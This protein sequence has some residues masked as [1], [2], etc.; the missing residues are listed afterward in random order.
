MS[1]KQIAE[2]LGKHP[3]TIR[4]ILPK[5]VQEGEVKTIEY[6]KYIPLEGVDSVDS[7]DTSRIKKDETRNTS[8]LFEKK[9]CTSE[10]GKSTES[11]EST[12]AGKP[13]AEPA[14][15]A[16][17][18]NPLVPPPSPAASDGAEPDAERRRLEE[19]IAFA[20][21]DALQP[22]TLMPSGLTPGWRIERVPKEER[23]WPLAGDCTGVFC[24]GECVCG[25]HLCDACACEAGALIDNHPWYYERHQPR[26]GARCE[27]C[28]APA[29]VASRW[30]T[31]MCERC[32]QIAS[33]G[34]GINPRAYQP[35]PFGPIEGDEDEPE[36]AAAGE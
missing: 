10:L 22:H 26:R 25:D 28:F 2:A 20:M 15:A 7:V 35:R 30:K 33:R 27:Y 36:D 14:P 11:T 34:L 13:E 12:G 31:P 17:D 21:P 24:Q 19:F 4:S 6:G 18:E 3:S 9:E 1:P 32:W 29:T 16:G 5:M 23:L 8:P